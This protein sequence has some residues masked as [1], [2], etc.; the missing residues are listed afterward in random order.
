MVALAEL[1]PAE[2]KE[3]LSGL[4]RDISL[5]GAHLLINRDLP[6]G[7]HI[8]VTIPFTVDGKSK[9]VQRAAEITRCEPLAAARVGLW[10]RSIGIRFTLPLGDDEAPLSSLSRAARSQRPT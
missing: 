2:A 4:L 3:P 8:E 7:S 5:S 9:V 1:L 10:T 6:V